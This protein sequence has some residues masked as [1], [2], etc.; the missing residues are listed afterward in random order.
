MAQVIHTDTEHRKALAALDR[1]LV[2]DPEPGTP[3]ANEL[4]LLALTIETY[5]KERF[6]IA[7]PDPVDAIRFRMDQA[8]LSQRDL[9]PYLGSKSKASEVLS[10]KRP[11]TLSMIRALHDGLGIP[12]DVLLQRI[13]DAEPD[14]EAESPDWSRMPVKEMARR[15]WLDATPEQLRRDAAD[16]AQRWFARLGQSQPAALFRTSRHT[17]SAREMNRYALTAWTARVLQLAAAQR[18]T[19]RTKTVAVDAQFMAEVAHLSVLDNGPV[20]ARDYLVKHGIALVAEPHFPRTYLDGAAIFGDGPVIG[21]TLRYDRLDNFWFTLMHELAHVALHTD[22]GIGA[23]YD[24][25]DASSEP[26]SR[27]SEADT[28]AA[29]ALI[30]RTAW[31][32]WERRAPHSTADVEEFAR[33]IRVHPAVVA[34]R[35]RHETGDFRTFSRMHGGGGVL[36]LLA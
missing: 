21:L 15:R 23:Y 30:P 22:A 19:A 7:P 34:G 10:G 16:L 25:L 14:Y 8:G 33:S 27:E 17:R 2:L 29:D 1:L 18:P 36:Q 5:E 20:A 24:D 35:L 6:P 13:P 26:D 12:S 31:V 11:L 4:E 3:E 9:V 32:E 28:L